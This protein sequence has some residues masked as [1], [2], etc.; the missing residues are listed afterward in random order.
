VPD[1]SNSAVDNPEA[2]A[3]TTPMR[4]CFM[5]TPPSFVGL[6]RYRTAWT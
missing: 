6:V 1:T 4:R 3:M 5:G 2:N